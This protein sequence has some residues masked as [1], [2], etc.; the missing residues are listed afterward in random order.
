MAP[1][2]GQHSSGLHSTAKAEQPRLASG[3]IQPGRPAAL[4]LCAPVSN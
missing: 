2:K 1:G 4:S 3:P